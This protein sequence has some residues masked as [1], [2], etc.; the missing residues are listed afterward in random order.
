MELRDTLIHILKEKDIERETPYIIDMGNSSW[1]KIND[2]YESLSLFSSH[3]LVDIRV[4]TEKLPAE[5][6]KWLDAL[7]K[8]WHPD[9]TTIIS[10]PKLDK[11]ALNSTWLK[12]L[13]QAGAWITATPALEGASFK[14]WVELRAAH[15]KLSFSGE[16]LS[17]FLI[18]M[19]GNLFAARQCFERLWLSGH[20]GNI[21]ETQLARY[22]DHSARYEVQQLSEAWLL[23]NTARSL[24][25]LSML[26]AEDEMI[27]LLILWQ[28]GEDL[29]AW[30]ALSHNRTPPMMWG[31]RKTALEKR[32]RNERLDANNF[33]KKIEQL[34]E[35]EKMTKGLINHKG[36]I[37]NH[38]ERMIIQWAN[39]PNI[40]L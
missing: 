25:I 18:L 31:I 32:A 38:I 5:G 26:R 21:N 37:W 24:E 9:V 17:Q 30:M 8:R 34:I 29:H 16:I 23:K 39:H 14:E 20:E 1:E 36:D 35:L 28:L 4:T 22:T 13:E 11:T 27:I 3:T 33:A 6:S 7:P 10:L 40:H 15:Y 19:E 2:A 12:N